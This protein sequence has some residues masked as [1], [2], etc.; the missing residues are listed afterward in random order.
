[1]KSKQLI[2]LLAVAAI[3]CGV[4]W[5]LKKGSK[6]TWTDTG[7]GAGGKVI[8]FPINDVARVTIHSSAGTA[9]LARKDDAW[10][11]Q[12]RADYPANFERVSNLLR[13]LWDLKTVQEIKVG[14]SQF[15]RFDLV[16]PAQGSGAGTRV[17]FKDKDGKSLGALLLGKK[18]MKQSDGAFGG[19]E[20]P[21]GRYVVQPGGSKVSLVSDSL[22]DV[23]PKPESWLKRDFIKIENASSVTLAGP[24]D[25][26][27]WKLSRENASS[28]W[29]LAGAKP[30]EK[31][32]AAKVSQYSTVLTY[33]SFADV[34]NPDA[35][36]ADTGLDK[37]TVVTFETFDGFK[38]VLNAG[39]ETNGNIPVTVTVSATLAAERTPGKDEKPEDKTRLDEEFKTKR[40]QF[41]EKL[42]A[43]K[44]F[45]G[46]PYLIAKA[47][48]DQV[49][50]DRTALLEDKKPEPA[51][52]TP[53]PTP[54]A[55][56][57]APGIPPV[58]PSPQ[59]KSPPAP[60]APISVT[61]PPVA[62][63]P[64][65]GTPPAAKPPQPGKKPVTATTPPLS[66]PKAGQP[67]K[68]RELS[69]APEK[70]KTP[71]K[72]SSPTPDTKP[73]PPK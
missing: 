31:V 49:I 68:V 63:P 59:A 6:D 25:A 36:P 12:E 58:P 33:A 7:G 73:A 39:K 27:K 46:R 65:P 26:Q 37:P 55:P 48:M 14:Q 20:F 21:A 62:V 30:E 4:V 17:D 61:T 13:K 60:G 51:P 5:F 72:P 45:E 44:K 35:K 15:A 28:D 43:E 50:K 70:P 41:E 69:P 34:L 47:T 1:M 67:Q 54:G 11:V 8:E 2:V 18:F 32:D 53:A 38:Y 22:D 19:G 56:G 9:N 10:T 29:K 3:L 23:E 57:S 24:A 42:A 16:D 64:L 52:G 40:K 66:A 71:E